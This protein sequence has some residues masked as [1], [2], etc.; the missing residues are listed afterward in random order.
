[1]RNHTCSLES[2][3]GYPCEVVSPDHSLT[4]T[5]GFHDQDRAEFVI[6]GT[7]SHF[8]GSSNVGKSMLGGHGFVKYFCSTIA[9]LATIIPCI[10]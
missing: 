8:F 7:F 1:M 9:S 6:L 10:C 5:E 3:S 4:S 2:L